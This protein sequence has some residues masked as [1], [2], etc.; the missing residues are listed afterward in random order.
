MI[1]KIKS[2]RGLA[3]TLSRLQAKGKKIVFTNGCFD[4]IHSGHIKYLAK[5]R[6]L[7]DVLVVGLNSDLSIKAIKGDSRP[8][9]NE[10][11][12]ALVLSA[13][14]FVDYVAIFGEDTPERLIKQLKPDILVKGGDWKVK[15]IVGGEFVISRGGKVL[16]IPFVKGFSTTSIIRKMSGKSK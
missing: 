5:A 13:L 16:S 8:L 7:G 2:A 6:S 14:Y 1:A 11:A 10:K 9:N 12:R 15:D 4:I 3:N